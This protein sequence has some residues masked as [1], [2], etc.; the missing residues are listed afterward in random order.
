[1]PA[2]NEPAGRSSETPKRL[3]WESWPTQLELALSGAVQPPARTGAGA[4]PTPCGTTLSGGALRTL[5]APR[6]RESGCPES[7]TASAPFS[8]SG[9]RTGSARPHA[10]A[11]PMLGP[12]GRGEGCV[13][14]LNRRSTDAPPLRGL[15]RGGGDRTGERGRLDELVGWHEASTRHSSESSGL[16]LLVGE[17]M[18]LISPS[19][20][21]DAG[22]FHRGTKTPGSPRRIRQCEISS[23]R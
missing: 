7:A 18:T 4:T 10:G 1:M 11:A 17:R 5:G 21:K 20:G 16:L 3:P 23:R 19:G 22:G 14:G 13:V 6:G 12:T 9:T 2:W 8:K 15:R